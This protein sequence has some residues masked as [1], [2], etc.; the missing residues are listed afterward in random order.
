MFSLDVC[1]NG[2][3]RHYS[4]QHSVSLP[5]LKSFIEN[6]SFISL[7]VAMELTKEWHGFSLAVYI[8]VGR[9][10][11]ICAPF[12]FT[13]SPW[14]RKIKVGVLM[15]HCETDFSLSDCKQQVGLSEE[16]RGGV[17]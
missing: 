15:G 13:L 16:G 8:R 3:G 6:Q 1:W 4:C 2:A 9:V 5:L 14:L 17:T 11:S 12:L 7:N 10:A